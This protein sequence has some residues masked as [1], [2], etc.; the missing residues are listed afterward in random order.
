M[1]CAV[2]DL[3]E[4]VVVWLSSAP[5]PATDTPVRIFHRRGGSAANVAA[6]AAGLGGASR[7]IGRV[8]DDALGDRLVAELAGA[9]V[10]A[11][12]QRSGRTG[13]IVVLVDAGG[14]RTML[15]DRG[16]SVAL[17]AV[18]QSWLA[19]VTVLHVPAYS[20]T[21]EPIA[22][23][24]RTL[25]AAARA[26]G[27]P[28]SVDASSVAVLEAF[29]VERFRALVE[30]LA[31]AVVLA[32][33]AEAAALGLTVAP[34]APVTVVK[35]GARPV[36]IVSGGDV[37]CQAVPV[38]PVDV[39]ADT[40]GAGDAFAAGFLTAWSAGVPVVE[41]VRV[42]TAVA[43]TVLG[44]PGAARMSG[45]QPVVSDEVAAALADGRAVVALE[46]TIFSNLGLPGPANAEAMDRCMAAVREP[47]P[48]P[49]S[50]PCSTAWPASGSTPRARSDLRTGPQ[51]GRARPGRGVGTAV[52]VRRHDGVGGAR[53]G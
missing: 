4:D 43:A 45:L 41:A 6:F 51:S 10:D 39:V 3:V 5:S 48:C 23:A 21:A 13:T 52:D 28:L 37:P 16:A 40:T 47:G 50:P 46:S 44:R 26:Q 11:R 9:G 34:L 8:G 24:C 35:D 31:P 20:L 2:G 49:P 22:S 25:A 18:P 38:P 7:F 32:N 17:R 53:P 1:L 15:P 14:E 12:V 42:G 36:V 27:V 33:A 30:R 19:G 29:G